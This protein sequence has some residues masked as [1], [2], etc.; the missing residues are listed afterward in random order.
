M[1]PKTPFTLD[2]LLRAA[3]APE[4]AGALKS[5]IDAMSARQAQQNPGGPP[6]RVAKMAARFDV[7]TGYDEDDGE[8]SVVAA[9]SERTMDK[10]LET[11]PVDE[12]AQI[13]DAV[14]GEVRTEILRALV[15]ARTAFNE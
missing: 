1:N 3:T 4:F 12:Y 7:D 2:D 6:V 11:V 15:A 5:A 14:A 8:F 9:W 10:I 13:A